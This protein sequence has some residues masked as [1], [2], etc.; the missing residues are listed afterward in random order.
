MPHPHPTFFFVWDKEKGGVSE[1][2]S[3]RWDSIVSKYKCMRCDDLA[4]FDLFFMKHQRKNKN[5]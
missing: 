5:Y 4:Y 2:I 3:I 1:L